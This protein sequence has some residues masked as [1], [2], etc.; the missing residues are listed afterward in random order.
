MQ[1]L[2]IYYRNIE[3]VIEEMENMTLDLKREIIYNKLKTLLRAVRNR[4]YLDSINYLFPETYRKYCNMLS[5][6]IM[7]LREGQ[8]KTEFSFEML[9]SRNFPIRS[10]PRFEVH[11]NITIKP[12]FSED[13]WNCYVQRTFINENRIQ[14][15]FGSRPPIQD[16]IK[17]DGNVFIR[18]GDAFPMP[19]EIGFQDLDRIDKREPEN[20]GYYLLDS[21]NPN[22]GQRLVVTE[23]VLDVTS[24]VGGYLK[25]WSERAPDGS[26]VGDFCL[27]YEKRSFNG[28][29]T[30][31]TIRVTV[32]DLLR[33]TL[34]YSLL[35]KDEA[36]QCLDKLKNSSSYA[37]WKVYHEIKECFKNN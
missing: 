37:E 34:G 6:L 30:A 12:D 5:F 19:Y 3:N 20:K 32:R 2:E 8:Y 9:D 22:F 25:K 4:E 35:T 21:V 10:E 27:A 28:P 33:K 16:T 36:R 24:F 15:A 11:R 14:A 29:V 7:K 13:V 18:I 17:I 23:T 26:C 31:W 1:E